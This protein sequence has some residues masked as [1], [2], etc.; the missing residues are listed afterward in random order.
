MLLPGNFPNRPQLSDCI[1][2]LEAS[3]Q[4]E[5]CLWAGRGIA[6]PPKQAALTALTTRYHHEL[7]RHDNVTTQSKESYL[8]LLFK[9]SAH[10]A[11]S[12]IF[13]NEPLRGLVRTRLA[14]GEGA[15]R[16]QL[17][18]CIKTDTQGKRVCLL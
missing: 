14:V 6:I 15:V 9:D 13:T 12:D 11:H 2:H 1:R 10:E 3:L 5:L 17:T 8:Y 4:T 18:H 7:E 16:N